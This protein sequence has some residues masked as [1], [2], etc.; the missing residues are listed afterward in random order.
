MG[1]EIKYF[2]CVVILVVYG[3]VIYI[4]SIVVE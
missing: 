4:G 1:N 3:S 2:R